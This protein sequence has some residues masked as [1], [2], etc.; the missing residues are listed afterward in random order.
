MT[1]PRT[2]LLD[3]AKVCLSIVPSRSSSFADSIPLFQAQCRIFAQNYNPDAIRTGNKVL[4][5]RLRGPALASYYPRRTV[6]FRDLQDAYSP[7]GLETCNDKEENRLESIAKYVPTCCLV[8]RPRFWIRDKMA[9]IFQP[10][11][12]KR[13]ERVRP[14]RSG[15]KVWL[16]NASHFRSCGLL[17]TYRALADTFWHFLQKLAARKSKDVPFSLS[18][19]TIRVISP[20]KGG[21]GGFC[22]TL[23][24]FQMGLI[25]LGVLPFSLRAGNWN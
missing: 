10:T 25:A 21:G 17:S 16:Y 14:R 4:R 8:D 3:L 23:G 18:G 24:V 20:G 2:R 22:M 15:R 5:Q 19:S 1:V 12:R 6:T 7:L 9:N 13:A 11:V